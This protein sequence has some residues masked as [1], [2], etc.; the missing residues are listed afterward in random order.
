MSQ[1]RILKL[2]SR[3][4]P[5]AIAQSRI[6]KQLLEDDHPDVQ[7]DIVGMDTR[8]DRDR[9]TPLSQTNDA[10]FFNAE[11]DAALRAGDI[12]FCVHSLKDLAIERPE[13]FVIAAIPERENPRDVVLF[14]P[15]AAEKIARGEPLV[16]GT[17][18]VRRAAGIKRFLP[19]VL[20]HTDK[21]AVIKTTDLRGPIDQRLQHLQD[22]ADQNGSEPMDGIV[23]A[24]A[25]LN[26]LYLDREG[27]EIIEPLLAGLRRV[28]LPV[29][30]FPCA[31]GQAAL[32]VECRADD[33]NTR[34]LL[35][36]IH[37]ETAARSVLTERALL[38]Q[39]PASAQ[40]AYSA[41]ALPH[42]LFDV[43]LWTSDDD[44]S[45]L[46]WMTPAAPAASRPW[47][48]EAWR[49]ER[50]R[51]PQPVTTAINNAP[52]L[53]IAHANALPDDLTPAGHIWTSG[54]SSWK[55]LAA[56]GVWVEGCAENLGFEYFKTQFDT[57][58]LELP[59]WAEWTALT[60]KDAVPSWAE[61]GIGVIIPTYRIE[62]EAEPDADTRERIHA[63]SHFFWGS[64]GEYEA[65]HKWVPDH[66]HH[67]CGPGKTLQALLDDGIYDVEPFPSRAEWLNWVT[68]ANKAAANN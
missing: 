8:G 3:Q 6:V 10:D 27:A 32:A 55:K 56:R 47:N 57:Q 21:P 26:R 44:E 46:H 51:R 5:L 31:P 52:A 35:G 7:I 4:S 62:D 25:G 63:S 20:P 29:S 67:A 9:N 30:E 48:D 1:Q 18:S 17:S 39:Q 59:Q 66:A 68:P 33:G 50:T 34:L 54:I 38:A 58:V 42:P 60:H 37:D 12:D 45:N 61:S 2:G 24:L 14:R 40:N 13:D 28:V 16:I 64:F 19:E 49:S 53:F 36:S 15:D 65:L 11:L 22:D 41:T 43:L 23:M